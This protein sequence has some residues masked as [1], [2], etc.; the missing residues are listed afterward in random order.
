MQP[1]SVHIICYIL[2]VTCAALS[3]ASLTL[4]ICVFKVNNR[5]EGH[6]RYFPISVSGFLP[7]LEMLLKSRPVLTDIRRSIMSWKLEGC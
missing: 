5:I 3:A 6:L 7:N 1:Y 4:K 2:S